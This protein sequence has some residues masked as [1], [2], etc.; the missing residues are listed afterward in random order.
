MP[1][2]VTTYQAKGKGHIQYLSKI[3]ERIWA[4]NDFKIPWAVCLNEAFRKHRQYLLRG[5]ALDII[6]SMKDKKKIN[7]E[8]SSDSGIWWKDGDKWIQ[9]ERAKL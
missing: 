1:S 3:A 6:S 9:I 5:V 4:E 8:K 7:P 2:P